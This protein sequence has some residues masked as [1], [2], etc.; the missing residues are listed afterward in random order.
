MFFFFDAFILYLSTWRR[1]R[2]VSVSN[3]VILRGGN[4][5]VFS[6]MLYFL[7]FFV[8]ISRKGMFQKFR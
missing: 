4:T 1:V 3:H 2:Y 6:I 5:L 7:V 8:K